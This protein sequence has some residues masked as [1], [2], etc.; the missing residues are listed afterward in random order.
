MQKHLT[1][2]DR[3][4]IDY[5]LTL[6]WTYTEIG[7]R[8]KRSRSVIS[9]EINRNGGMDSYRYGRAHQRYL[10]LRKEAKIYQL[11][12]TPGSKLSHFVEKLIKKSFSPE[13]VA[14]RI[15]LEYGLIISHETIYKW[16]YEFRRDLQKYLRCQK[17]QWR[18]KRGTKKREKSRR[19]KQ[20]K[21]IDTRPK[22]IEKRI[23]LGDWEGDTVIG[24]NR[25]NRILTYVDRTSGY[26]TAA[27]LHKVSS[28]IVQETT[29]ELFKRFPASKRKTITFD[30]GTEF[31]GDDNIIEKFTKTSVY[32]AHAYHS[33]ERGTNENWNGLLRQ[34]FPK[35]TDFTTISQKKVS[36]VVRII[37]HRPRKRLNYFTPHEVFVLGFDPRVAS[38]ARM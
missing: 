19:M 29:K 12:L 34:F 20:F 36:S 25:K 22:I 30:R 7:K 37:N 14:G 24:K 9:R 1:K 5:C 18:R 15:R 32:R 11:K 35:G 13:Q 28:E 8:L 31:G 33:W 21:C 16:I 27:V 23:R 26:A 38:H 2:E 3:K 17:G 6:S 4:T 10:A